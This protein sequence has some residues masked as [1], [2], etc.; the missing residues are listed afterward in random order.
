MSS[1][2]RERA[3]N[4]VDG[5]NMMRKKVEHAGDRPVIVGYLLFEKSQSNCSKAIRNYS[6]KIEL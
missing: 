2:V 5:A 1:R 4:K 6:K 3:M